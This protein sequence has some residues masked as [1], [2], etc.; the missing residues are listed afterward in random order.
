MNQM[1]GHG[2]VTHAH[3]FSVASST[4]QEID[5]RKQRAIPSLK[6]K[7][8]NGQH[9]VIRNLSYVRSAIS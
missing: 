2:Q 4:N 8:N 5:A 9:Y 7:A 1:I 3:T 6:I